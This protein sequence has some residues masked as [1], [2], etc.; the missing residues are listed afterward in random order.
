M[1]VTASKSGQPCTK[2]VEVLISHKYR[3]ILPDGTVSGGPMYYMKKKDIY[4]D[5]KGW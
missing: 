3:D 5:E 4:Q 1:L 2:F